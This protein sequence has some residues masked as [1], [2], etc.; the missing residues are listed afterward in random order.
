[1][2]RKLASLLAVFA[3]LSGCQST[4]T[5]GSISDFQVNRQTSGLVLMSTTVNTGE[6]PPLSVVTVKSLM[7]KKSEDYLLYNQI[8]GKSHSTSLF[9]GSL[10]AGEYRISKVAAAIPTGS[11]Y[12]NIDDASV[13][14]TFTVKAGEVADLGRL[15]FSALDLK[16]AWGAVSTL[17]P[18][19]S[20][21]HASSQLS[22]FCKPEHSMAGRSRIRK[23]MW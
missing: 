8:G 14:G 15:V 9:W 10:P 17:C 5:A 22:K 23:L 11:K 2:L 12:L 18:M 7:G 19:T 1:M 21:W 3:L 6:I 13:L 20:W 4:N 16:A